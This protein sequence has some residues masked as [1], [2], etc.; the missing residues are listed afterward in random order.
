MKR[1]RVL[2]TV[3]LTS[4]LISGCM[5]GPNYHRPVVQTPTVYRNLSENPQ[6]CAADGDINAGKR[7]GE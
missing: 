7:R 3:I 1:P 4:S 5:V 6:A 2:V